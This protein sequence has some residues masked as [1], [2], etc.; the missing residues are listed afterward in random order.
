MIIAN[1]EA[2]GWKE[3]TPKDADFNEDPE[4]LFMSSY[5]Q[6]TKMQI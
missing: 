5:G 3:L 6:R 2:I 1:G 4:D